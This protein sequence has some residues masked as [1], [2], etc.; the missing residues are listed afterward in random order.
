MFDR[1]FTAIIANSTTKPFTLCVKC[2]VIA[3]KCRVPDLS[4]LLKTGLPMRFRIPIFYSRST[5][6]GLG[7]RNYILC[8]LPLSMTIFPFPG[9]GACQNTF[10]SVIMNLFLFLGNIVSPDS[11]VLRAENLYAQAVG[12]GSAGRLTR[13]R[14]WSLAAATSACA[15]RYGTDTAA[16]LEG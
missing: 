15:H 2:C 9:N 5:S 14:V 4:G 13:C 6:A 16:Q 3:A 10:P 1:I 7:F 12:G 8:R 11:Y